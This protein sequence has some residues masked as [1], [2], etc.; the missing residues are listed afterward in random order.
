MV[1]SFLNSLLPLHV[2]QVVWPF[3]ALHQGF[4]SDR[5]SLQPT[6]HVHLGKRS[7][8]V[9][10]VEE[11]RE[12][13]SP[14]S[15]GWTGKRSRGQGQTGS[16]QGTRLLGPALC[17]DVLHAL[18]TGTLPKDRRRPHGDGNLVHPGRQEPGAADPGGG[19][20]ACPTHSTESKG[21]FCA[22]RGDLED[23]CGSQDRPQVTDPLSGPRAS[24]PCAVLITLAVGGGALIRYSSI[25]N[26]QIEGS[27]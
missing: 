22:S 5:S 20:V 24:Q 17:V 1:L 21:G 14:F 3:W 12:T 15:W 25:S 10:L 11:K 26:Q 27:E 18:W 19:R 2:Q 4:L 13:T 16:E 7:H 9:S 6:A 23:I 8:S